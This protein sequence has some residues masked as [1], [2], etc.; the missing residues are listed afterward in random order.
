VDD[1]HVEITDMRR[2]DDPLDHRHPSRLGAR[3]KRGWRLALAVGT[4]L[5]ALLVVAGAWLHEQ[6]SGNG[7]QSRYATPLPTETTRPTPTP[8]LTPTPLPVT[9]PLAAPPT[10]C[11][12]SPPLD[13]LTVPAFDGFIN[14]DT[15]PLLGRSPVWVVS[16]PP[17]FGVVNLAQPSTTSPSWPEI[18]IFWVFGPTRHPHV[19][20][21]A[22]DLHSGEV[23][24]WAVA[25]PD[26]PQIP[27]LSMDPDA[28]VPQSAQQTWVV[29]TNHLF[30]MHAG[31]YKLDVSWP[32]GGWQ[33]VFAAGQVRS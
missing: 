11:P 9:G 33:T 10:N 27:I 28:G 29:E 6:A 4:T 5:L 22:T 14:S 30:I 26:T 25:V 17:S 20:V 2:P 12:A 19:T 15:V 3:A 32:G 23:A 1:P 21:R 24:W 18:K 16:D 13:A 7:A 31:C 8:V